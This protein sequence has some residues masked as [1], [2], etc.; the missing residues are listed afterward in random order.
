MNGTVAPDLIGT[1]C[2]HRSCS[3]A[4]RVH[5]RLTVGELGFCMHHWVHVEEAM[6]ATPSFV[7]ASPVDTLLP[8]GV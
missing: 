4:V 1:T 2:D 6:V 3:A 8:M 7:S 5:A